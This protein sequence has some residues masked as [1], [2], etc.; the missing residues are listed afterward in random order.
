[1]RIAFITYEYP[2]DTGKGGIGTY[3]NQVAAMLVEKKWDVHV[4]CGTHEN[5]MDVEESG[6]SI[7]KVKCS[8]PHDFTRNVTGPFLTEHRLKAFDVVETPEIHGNAA[9]IK[10]E[11]PLLP[12]VIRLHAPNSLV[13]QT[14]K[15]YISFAQKLR[16]VLGA[17]RRFKWDAG[18][19]KK[20]D[21]NN[22]PDYK[23]MHTATRIVAPSDIMKQWAVK[24]WDINE[25][26]I[27]VIPNIF[28]PAGALLQLPVENIPNNCIVFFG[29]LNVLKGIV[30]A[31][32][33]MKSVLRKNKHWR[34][35]VIGNDGPGPG[36]QGSMRS[37]MAYELKDQSN[38][39]VFENGF[40]YDQLPAHLSKADIVILPSL[41]E[42]FS[43]ACLEAMAAGKAVIGS[44]ATG[45]E[46]IISHGKDGILADPED[47]GDIAEKIAMLIADPVKRAAIS[48]EARIT[49][50][51]K[52]TAAKLFSQYEQL[53][54]SVCTLG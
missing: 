41:F 54:K 51:A 36:G 40:E 4:F 30:N 27:E 22:D 10:K 29:R 49:A 7:H 8:G 38:Q 28:S 47:A 1:M 37:W 35:L 31:T 45:M 15:R 21:K 18:Y 44:R 3:T 34:F 16:F 52:F 12:L 2:P 24:N 39:V 42:S 17:M 9:A 53:Y 26:K 5:D 13:E 33:A 6:I 46:S 11:L 32:H 20:Y 25:N 23:Q 48:V 19:W 50:S 14:K 43:Y